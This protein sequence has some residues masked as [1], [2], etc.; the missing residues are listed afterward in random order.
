MTRRVDNMEL[1]MSQ[2]V[3]KVDSVL[4][5]LD[6]LQMSKSLRHAN[7]SKILDSFMEHPESKLNFISTY[8][9]RDHIKE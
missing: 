5:K 1:A 4:G 8:V 9:Q 2:I 6:T 3:G 7:M